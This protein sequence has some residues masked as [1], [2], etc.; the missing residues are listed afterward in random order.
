MKLLYLLKKEPSA[1]IV[2]MM[3]QHQ[4]KAKI[5]VIDMRENKNYAEIIDQVFNNDK[6]ITW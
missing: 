4:E 3:K 1:S 2:A 5:T 6:I